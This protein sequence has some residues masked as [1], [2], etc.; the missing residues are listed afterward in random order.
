MA[1]MPVRGDGVFALHSVE[2]TG[3]P[4]SS[5]WCNDYSLGWV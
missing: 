5:W 3:V 4:F 1:K 2:F